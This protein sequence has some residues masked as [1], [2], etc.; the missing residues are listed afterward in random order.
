MTFFLCFSKKKKSAHP[1]KELPPIKTKS[2]KCLSSSISGRK[3]DS[4]YPDA[5]ND[6]LPK[7]KKSKSTQ[8]TYKEYCSS[9]DSN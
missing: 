9:E 1:T 6:F 8:R 7:A 3:R 5:S 4:P 2:D